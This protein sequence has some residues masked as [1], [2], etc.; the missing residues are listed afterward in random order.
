VVGSG[1][2]A[3]IEWTRKMSSPQV[4]GKRYGDHM[5]DVAKLHEKF[6]K[7]DV[8]EVNKLMGNTRNT[9]Q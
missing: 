1:D 5:K 6:F 9:A 2:S 3:K 7:E 4:L 8:G